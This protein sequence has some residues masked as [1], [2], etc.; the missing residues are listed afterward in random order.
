MMNKIRLAPRRGIAGLN[1]F[2]DL[3]ESGTLNRLARSRGILHTLSHLLRE[4]RGIQLIA[5]PC[6]P[7]GASDHGEYGHGFLGTLEHGWQRRAEPRCTRVCG[8]SR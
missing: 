2:N 7:E 4:H 5:A 8:S 3:A 6:S 1:D